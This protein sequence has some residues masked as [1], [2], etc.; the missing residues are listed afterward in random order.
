MLH[1]LCTL[2]TPKYRLRKSQ[3]SWRLSA[4]AANEAVN[5]I[6]VINAQ[7]QFVGCGFFVRVKINIKANVTKGRNKKQSNDGA[8]LFNLDVLK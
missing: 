4:A 8:T 2:H 6:L 1:V 5:K 7:E 3:R